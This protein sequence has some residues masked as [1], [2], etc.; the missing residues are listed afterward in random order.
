MPFINEQLNHNTDQ[1]SRQRYEQQAARA[2]RFKFD[3]EKVISALQERIVGQLPVLSAMQDMLYTLKADFGDKNRPLSVMLFMGPTGVGK[4]ETVRVLAES[5]LGSKDRLCRIDMN[6]LAQEHYSAALTGSPPGYVGS[7]EGQTLFDVEKI[8]GSFSEPGI[9]LFDEIEKADQSV[10]RSLMNIL[11][12]GK[13][14]LTS[15]MNEIDFSNALI[16]MTSNL[17]AQELS[18]TLKRY[19]KGWRATFKL[20]PPSQTAIFEQALNTH[21]DPEFINRI[22]QVLPFDWLDNS[23]LESLL[24]LELS[25]LN[26]RLRARKASIRADANACQY[27]SKAYDTR[28]GARDI[29]RRIRIEL[30]PKLAQAMLHHPEQ[31]EFSISM[32]SG[33][34][35]VSHL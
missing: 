29:A 3:P 28:Y 16:F 21:F 17:G 2:S 7:K 14:T 33:K 35:K 27:L 18:N 12:T 30:E 22:D 13:L 6:T 1:I 19:S 31:L 4:T 32:E 24:N 25:K 20:K 8:K 23:Q 9:V 10:V 15:G 5:I 11:D 26:K 34:L